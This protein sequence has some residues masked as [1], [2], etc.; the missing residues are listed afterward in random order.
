MDKLTIENQILLSKLQENQDKVKT[1]QLELLSNFK[2]LEN[3]KSEII[4]LK[5]L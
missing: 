5:N 3:L 1:Q 2:E 4:D